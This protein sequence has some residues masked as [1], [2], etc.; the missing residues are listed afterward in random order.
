[1]QALL[2]ICD[3]TVAVGDDALRRGRFG[4]FKDKR[5]GCNLAVGRAFTGA[6]APVCFAG[7]EC[8]MGNRQ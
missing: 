7:R 8:G 5:A 6:I 2:V 4:V 1:V 3:A